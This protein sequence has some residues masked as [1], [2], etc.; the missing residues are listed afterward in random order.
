MLAETQCPGATNGCDLPMLKPEAKRLILN[1]PAGMVATVNTN[2]MPCVSPKA[3]FVILS[4]TALAFGN[5]RSP[6]TL[7]NIRAR[8][9]VEV[10]FIDVVYRKAVRVTG[11]ATIYRRADAD[12]AMLAA[13]VEGWSSL[14]EHMTHLVKID[15]SGCELIMSPAYDRG[16]TE[17]ELRRVNLEKLNAL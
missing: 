10:C 7:A 13:F 8:P 12:A 9:A 5:L 11:S 14:H 17:E 16:A 2:G 4:D 15:V 3:T 1:H 6:G